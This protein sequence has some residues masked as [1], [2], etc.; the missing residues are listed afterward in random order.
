ML[1]NA[2]IILSKYSVNNNVKYDMKYEY[3]IQFKISFLF[4]Y[5]FKITLFC[6]GEVEFEFSAAIY[7][8][9][10]VLQKSF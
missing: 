2:A 3:E 10:G 9:F 4:I 5:I 7:S 1:I 6:D 8:V